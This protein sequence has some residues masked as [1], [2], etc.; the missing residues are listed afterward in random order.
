[1]ETIRVRLESGTRALISARG[2]QWTADEP[3]EL[4]GGDS[5]PTPYELLL[6]SLGACT[7]VTLRLYAAHK[8]IALRS[9]DVRYEFSRVHAEDCEDCDRRS[10]DDRV[11]VIRAA[12]RLGGDFDERQRARLEQIVARC[13]VHKTLEKGVQIFEE[14]AF[15]A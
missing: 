7:A 15:G 13:P 10:Q 6:G 8:G 11:E 14:V 12:V 1:M 2:H 3:R 9:V 4:G 5:G